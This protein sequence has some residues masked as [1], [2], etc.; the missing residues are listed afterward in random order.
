MRIVDAPRFEPQALSARRGREP[1]EDP[2]AGPRLRVVGADVRDGHAVGGAVAG[3]DAVLWVLGVP[4]GKA[5]VDVYFR[6]AGHALG[7]M[8]RHGCAGWSWSAPAP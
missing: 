1:Y 6:G 5:P 2:G 8:A 4:F 7:A 3:S